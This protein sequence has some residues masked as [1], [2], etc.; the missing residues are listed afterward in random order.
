MQQNMGKM[1]AGIAKMQKQA[2]AIQDEIAKSKFE[3][4]AANGLVKVTI[5]GEGKLLDV[6]L[7]QA[8]MSED[9]ETVSDLVIV[10]VNKAHEGKEALAKQKLASLGAGLLPL[11]MKFPGMA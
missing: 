8:V 5:N 10:A 2:Q 4:A 9:A 6:K 11:G 7:D 3:G 1:L